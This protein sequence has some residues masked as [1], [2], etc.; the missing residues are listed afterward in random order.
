MKITQRSNHHRKAL[1][2][3]LATSLCAFTPG[4]TAQTQSAA[5]TQ[6]SGTAQQA[7]PPVKQMALTDKQIEG[8]LSSSNEMDAITAK[9]PENAAPD[10]KAMAQL[11]A[12]AK[13]HGFASF[14]DYSNVTDGMTH[15]AAGAIEAH[16][17][18]PNL[19]STT[20]IMVTLANN[21]SSIETCYGTADFLF[22]NCDDGS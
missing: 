5:Q 20:N 15:I 19:K 22:Q 12:V 8:V 13:K 14:D 21:M 18:C 3:I 4:L 17:T 11:D 1:A 16:I 10:A 6:S 7:P 2:L 9:L